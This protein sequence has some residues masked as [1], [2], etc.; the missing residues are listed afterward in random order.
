V[1][2][3]TPRQR[4]A[5]IAIGDSSPAYPSPGHAPRDV[6]D[7]LDRRGLCVVTRTAPGPGGWR[8]YLT[9][10][11]RKLALQLRELEGGAL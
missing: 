7:R 8:V 6:Y 9:E 11:G 10:P 5:I 4:E 2:G 3:L 1:R